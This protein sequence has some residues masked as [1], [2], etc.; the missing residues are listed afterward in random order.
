MFLAIILLIIGLAIL[1]FG[2]DIFVK[3][4]SSVAKKLKIPAIVIGLTIVSFGTSAPELIVNLLASLKG[5]SDL[6]IGNILGSNISNILLIL[7]L[8]AFFYPLSVKDKTVW[9]EIPFGVLSML[10]LLIISADIFLN[11][12]TENILSRGDGLVLL[13]FFIIFMVYTYGLTKVEDKKDDDDDIKI[14]NWPKSIFCIILGVLFLTFGG[15]MVVKNATILAKI[16][17]LSEL[18]IGLTITAI[19]TSLPELVTSLVAAYRKQMDLA[20]GNIIGSNIFNVLWI[21][22]LSSVI[23]PIKINNNAFFDILM[24]LLVSTLLF[25]TMFMGGKKYRNKISKYEGLV[26][27][28]LYIFYIIT[29]SIRG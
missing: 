28:L 13:S 15:H 11:K 29:I 19:G 26:F 16:A 27:L 1:I 14:Y 12:N 17:G 8:V 2:G 20:V 23:S 21:L 22:G 24:T 18:F 5:A 10:V 4:S 25:L 9:R 7:G 6:A 3:G